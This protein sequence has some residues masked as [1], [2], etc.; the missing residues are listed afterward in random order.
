[1]DA[2]A[3]SWRGRS[4]GPRAAAWIHARPRLLPHAGGHASDGAGGRPA[5]DA[6][7]VQQQC[8]VGV[9]AT[10]RRGRSSSRGDAA[11]GDGLRRRGCEGSS[12]GRT[13]G[14]GYVAAGAAGSSRA[15]AGRRWWWSW[16]RRWRRCARRWWCGRQC[17]TRAG[18]WRRCRRRTRRCQPGDRSCDTN[19][20]QTHNQA[21]AHCDGDDAGRVRPQVLRSHGCGDRC[22]LPSDGLT[23]ATVAMASAQA[24][25]T[26]QR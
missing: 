12:S 26:G 4:A 8:A 1:M 23:H 11:H 21:D 7:G 2:T 18:R 15:A 14:R 24:S 16:L 6:R 19:R 3:G 20:R 13:R 25:R 9:H 17:D 5:Y 22:V 10:T